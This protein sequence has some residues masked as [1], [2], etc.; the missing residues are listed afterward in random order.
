M[1]E[2]STGSRRI[3]DLACLVAHRPTVILLDEPSSGIAQRETEALAP[4]IDRIRAQVGASI[5]VIEHD[6]PLVTAVADRL[7]A[8]DLGRVLA[9]GS[10]RGAGAP[11]GGVL[12]RHERGG[13]QSEW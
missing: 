12:P 11:G 9:A 5:V 7:L 8:L 10:R 6:M 4:V 2:L 1:H 13:H 3:V